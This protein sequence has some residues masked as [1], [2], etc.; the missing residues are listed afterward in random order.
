MS[1]R[2][3]RTA[4]SRIRRAL[5]LACWNSFLAIA[6]LVAIAVA[7]EV[8]LRRTVPFMQSSATRRVHPEAGLLFRPHTEVRYTNRLDFWTVSRTNS[9]GFVDREPPSPER[10]A[11]TCHVAVFG[12]SF[13][14]AL[15]VPITE[16]FHV[17]LDRAANERRPDL[18]ITTSA[19]GRGG[20]AQVNQLAFYDQ[21][22]RHL[23][24]K[25]LVLV[26]VANDFWENS[27]LLHTLN[28]GGDR[29][30][31][32]HWPFASAARTAAG[33]I[34]LRPPDPEYRAFL[35]PRLQPAAPS[36]P[37]K[38]RWTLFGQWLAA[39]TGNLAGTNFARSFRS[40]D[41]Q[42]IADA[43]SLS[44]RPR[45]ASAT[46]GWT[47]TTRAQVR[48]HFLE[49]NPPPAFR[50][51]LAYMEFGLDEFQ[52]RARRD[53]SSVVILATETLSLLPRHLQGQRRTWL[54]LLNGMA[55]ERGIPVI[56]QFAY[57]ARRGGRLRD[58]RWVHDGHWSQ[59]GHRW[60]AEALL[61]HLERNPELCGE[62]Q[63]SAAAS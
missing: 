58:A 53:G 60:A 25:L 33:G 14:E 6:G 59:T 26:T 3:L 36:A 40:G 15:Q 1:A 49:D 62:R 4:S 37:G 11:E 35:L 45:F 34:A 2:A 39:K 27:T 28:A 47:P 21:F 55:E 10:A 54:D 50:E 56:D 48:W 7:A 46:A 61:E 30:D 24:P 18:A 57:I 41:P 23:R 17:V 32:D 52:R 20:T 43:Q 38:L 5:R 12:D 13:V 63:A 31:P 42:L 29:W 44:E 51:A 9:W 19:F 8:Y 22:A 16:K